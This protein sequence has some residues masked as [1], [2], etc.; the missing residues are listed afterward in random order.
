MILAMP[1]REMVQLALSNLHPTVIG[2]T[3]TQEFITSATHNQIYWHAAEYLAAG[4]GACG[5]VGR[6]RYANVKATQ[7]YCDVLSRDDAGVQARWSEAQALSDWISCRGEA[8]R[9]PEQ[10]F[11]ATV[12]APHSDTPTAPVEVK[13]Y[14]RWGSSPRGL[15]T[16]VLGARIR[17]LLDGR[18]NVALEDL[19]A[20]APAALRH[21]IFLNFEADAAGFTTDQVVAAVLQ[22][23]G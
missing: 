17:A 10:E 11:Y 3:V 19:A 21:R 16:L 15:Q 6:M 22:A 7:R 4:P 8:Y 9:A 20:V 13:R 1:P 23:T 14:V 18:F 2:K 12:L 5:F